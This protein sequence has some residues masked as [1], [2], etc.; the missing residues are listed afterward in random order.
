MD[1]DSILDQP[2]EASWSESTTPVEEEVEEISRRPP[3]HSGDSRLTTFARGYR[4]ARRRLHKGIHKCTGVQLQSPQLM[5]FP[6]LDLRRSMED[7]ESSSSQMTVITSAGS[8]CTDPWSSSGFVEDEEDEG[9]DRDEDTRDGS[10]R[11]EDVQ[12]EDMLVMKLEPED[13]D[14]NMADLL[15]PSAEETPSVAS[16]PVTAK[17]PRGRPRKHPKL[18]AVAKI[19]KGRSKTGC[20]TCRRRKKKCDERKPGCEL[21]IY[22]MQPVGLR[23][24][25]AQA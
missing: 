9:W 4:P 23:T 22:F 25:T 15:E 19:T 6:M 11:N 18:E 16:T 5:A 12:D 14:V 17:R 7:S 3:R 8:S 1:K 2:L 13:D 24:N 10:I 21:M 20:I